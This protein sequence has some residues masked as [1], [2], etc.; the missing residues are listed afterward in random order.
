MSTVYDHLISFVKEDKNIPTI[1][2]V[3]LLEEILRIKNRRCQKCEKTD[4]CGC[5]EV[6]CITCSVVD[7]CEG[8]KD[9]RSVVCHKCSFD[10][11]NCGAGFFCVKCFC[12]HKC[13][14]HQYTSEEEES[15][16]ESAS[17]EPEKGPKKRTKMTE[18]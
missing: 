11:D 6:V 13:Q 7:V 17:K 4:I 8:E 14:E 1:S 9:C 2:K 15:G 12:K 16:S 5:G 18:K 3:L 10:C